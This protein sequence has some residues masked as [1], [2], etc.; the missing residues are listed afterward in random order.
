M[1]LYVVGDST[2]AKFNDVSY[3]FSRYGYATKLEEYFNI[4]VINLAQSGRSARSYLNDKE[5]ETLKKSLQKGDFLLIGFGHNDQ[6]D[7]DVIRFSDARLDRFNPKSFKYVLYEYYIKL[8][9]NVGATPILATPIA[10]LNES[11]IY[12]GVT[13]HD[14]KYGNYKNAILDL[15][16]ELNIIAINLTDAS[17]NLYKK[18]TYKNAIYHHAITG[19][20]KKDG[21]LIANIKSVDKTHLSSYGAKYIAYIFASLIKETNS[22]LKNYLKELKEPT[23]KDIYIN[24]LYEY[25]DYIPY[26]SN[27]YKDI[28]DFKM[29]KIGFFKDN[30][31][32]K[33]Y[34]LDNS[35]I[36]ES[37][38]NSGVMH[39]TNDTFNYVF[40][41]ID[42]SDN[43][44]M[45]A[46]AKILNTDKIR[47]NSFG[48]MIRDTIY[49]SNNRLTND[50][51]ISCGIIS[52]DV[53]NILFSREYTTELKKEYAIKDYPNNLDTFEFELYRLGQR[54][55]I[56]LKY[57]DT[58]YKHD[59]YDFDIFAIDNNNY[60]VGMY[61]INGLKIEF[62]H[63]DFQ[64][65]SKAKGA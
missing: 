59:Y 50:N 20:I 8:A 27:D 52:Q 39:S 40:K 3:Y 53:T 13:I 30:T 65:T 17:K 1:K 36:I 33:I 7:D 15:A 35:I 16:K 60:Y 29:T 45:T 12:E 43:F 56:S 47:Q 25:I 57:N 23:K 22:P 32:E 5:Y 61:A 41:K 49:N 11:D 38:P 44:K 14:T 18:L 48:I 55:T 19:A 31:N 6:K 21:K 4:E 37:M 26:N 63:I 28:M 54:I 51:F 24:P 10:R 46:K 2:L 64:I 34:N 62:Y 9:L 58:I 42:K